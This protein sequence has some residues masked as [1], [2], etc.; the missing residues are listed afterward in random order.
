MLHTAQYS[1]R[2]YKFVEKAKA[3]SPENKLILKE[4]LFN[5]WDSE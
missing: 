5:Y 2:A 1:K 3:L 4:A